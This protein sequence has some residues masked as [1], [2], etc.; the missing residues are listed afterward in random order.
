PS[1]YRAACGRSGVPLGA[2]Q[3]SQLADTIR[4]QFHDR[5]V[6]VMETAHLLRDWLEETVWRELG[7]AL[8]VR[9]ILL[10]RQPLGKRIHDARR[11]DR[12][13]PVR[14]QGV[15]PKAFGAGP[16]VSRAS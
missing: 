3:R 10:S 4:F 16:C 1:C 11:L 7:N 14:D 2:S 8:A 13:D 6:T 9:A 12:S 15:T 5:S